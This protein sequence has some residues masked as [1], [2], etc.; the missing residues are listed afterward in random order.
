[1][2]SIKHKRFLIPALLGI[3][4]IGSLL[5][6]HR[7][8]TTAV[9]KGKT[10]A[11]WLEETTRAG[12]EIT[13]TRALREA[14]E[15]AAPDLVRALTVK[16]SFFYKRVLPRLP[17]PLR[18]FVPRDDREVLQDHALKLIRHSRLRPNQIVPILK[19]AIPQCDNEN[20]FRIGSLLI[21]LVQSDGSALSEVV[22]VIPDLRRAVERLTERPGYDLQVTRLEILAQVSDQIQKWVPIGTMLEDVNRIMDEHRFNRLFRIRDL[23]VN[24]VGLK[25][26]DYYPRPGSAPGGNSRIDGPY[27]EMNF[28]S[29]KVSSIRIKPLLEGS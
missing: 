14:G 15:V 28:L 16:Q 25:V 22:K 19:R 4:V 20:L 21:E 23:P 18:R 2:L 5:V 10:I 26:L 11:Q 13:A 8:D 24:V 3:A 12:T 27:I 6:F 7:S 9:Y 29:N 1:M 17:S